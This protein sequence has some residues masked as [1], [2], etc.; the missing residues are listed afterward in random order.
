M[1]QSQIGAPTAPTGFAA[2][3]SR[4]FNAPTPTPTKGDPFGGT[5]LSPGYQFP[6]DPV[7]A[8]AAGA[9]SPISA[10]AGAL[11][12]SSLRGMGVSPEAAQSAGNMAESVAPAIAAP[13]ASRAVGSL[14]NKLASAGRNL[15]AK[16]F[17]KGVQGTTM[18]EIAK[19]AAEKQKAIDYGLQ[20]EIPLSSAGAG[21]EDNPGLVKLSNRINALRSQKEAALADA[22]RSGATVDAMDRPIQNSQELEERYAN[23]VNP[24]SDVGAVRASRQEYLRKIGGNRLATIGPEEHAERYAQLQ[25]ILGEEAPPNP[26]ELAPSEAEAL[27]Q[28]TYARTKKAQ[29]MGSK[30]PGQVSN[31]KQLARGLKEATAEATPELADIN[32]ELS[33]AYALE[34]YAAKVTQGLRDKPMGNRTFGDID[35]PVHVPVGGY[36]KG[37]LDNAGARSKMAFAMRRAGLAKDMNQANA[38]L[39]ALAA[40]L[41]SPEEI[42]KAY[43]DG[44]INYDDA[45]EAARRFGYQ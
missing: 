5:P 44:T 33:G 26:T 40:T 22:D 25:D 16:Q 37:M 34:P 38:K 27:K 6:K 21:L 24:E 7:G 42:K 29:F 10:G 30:L 19:S 14:S 32:K 12:E 41:G 39:S 15:Y 8:A 3:V 45:L 18:E 1:G 11:T 4:Y 43:D 9:F 35:F 36:V 13:L 28:G 23:Q 20:N 17:P 2:R 31:E